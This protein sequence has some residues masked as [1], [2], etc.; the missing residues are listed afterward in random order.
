MLTLDHTMKMQKNIKEALSDNL[1]KILGKNGIDLEEKARRAGRAV[2]GAWNWA[3]EKISDIA[4]IPSHRNRMIIIENDVK[5]IVEDIRD[6][7]LWIMDTDN[8]TT[9]LEHFNNYDLDDISCPECNSPMRVKRNSQTQEFF[10]GCSKFHKNDCRGSLPISDPYL[11][12]LAKK[13][14]KA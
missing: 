7:K 11:E 6:L 13:Y 3:R 10:F 4:D 2:S 9:L 1:V 8:R 14:F 12:S 5:E